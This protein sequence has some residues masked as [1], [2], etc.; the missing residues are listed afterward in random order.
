MQNGHFKQSKNI[1]LS[2]GI[3]ILSHT[4]AAEPLTTEPGTA[5]RFAPDDLQQNGKIT[6]TPG[7]ALD[8]KTLYFAQS[9]CSQIGECPQRL[10]R[11]RLTER[12][13]STP[14][15]MSVTANGR[16]EYPSVSPDGRY[17][18]FSWATP[19]SRHANRGVN[20]DFDIYRLDLT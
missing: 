10:K 19:R 20:E 7:F 3:C 11:S 9:E 6:L 17:L 13:W 12:G 14:E 5:E 18:L 16:S 2:L 8:G 15:L 4:I 1:F